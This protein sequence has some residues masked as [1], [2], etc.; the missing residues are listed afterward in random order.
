[1]II[2]MI[3][4]YYCCG[5]GGTRSFYAFL[6]GNI[7]DSFKYNPIVLFGVVLLFLRWLEI[8]LHKK[9][10]P[11]NG[12]FWYSVLGIF[13]LFYIARNFIPCLAPI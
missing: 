5:C 9:I 4:G 2:N 8:I 11:K 12:F 10:I 13:L 6:E 3:T 1:C 7:I